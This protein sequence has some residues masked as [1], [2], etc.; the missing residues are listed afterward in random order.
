MSSTNRIASP[1]DVRAWAL[2]QGKTVGERGKFSKTL[3]AEYN[4]THKGKPY[5][6][7]KFVPSVVLTA[8]PE[9]GRAKTV[10]LTASERRAARLAVGAGE[11]GRLSPAHVAAIV[12]GQSAPAPTA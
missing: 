2:A 1:A 3:I 4:K 10:A 8:K 12:L 6:Q 7:G 11:R 9:K 5:K